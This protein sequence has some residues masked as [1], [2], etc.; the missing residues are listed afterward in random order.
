VEVEVKMNKKW[1]Y[2]RVFDVKKCAWVL[3]RRKF[4]YDKG[5]W[6]GK[7]E[8]IRWITYPSKE[9]KNGDKKKRRI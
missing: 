9:D 1:I 6:I 5:E 3:R 2:Y 8:F 7:S 4:D